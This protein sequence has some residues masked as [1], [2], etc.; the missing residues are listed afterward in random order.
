MPVLI[1][2]NCLVLI[3]IYVITLYVDYLIKQK[4][5]K[6]REEFVKQKEDEAI[7]ARQE[8]FEEKQEQEEDKQEQPQVKKITKIKKNYP[9]NKRKK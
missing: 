5:A 4:T 7:K 8:S 6:K 1:V 3:A 2:I 9:K